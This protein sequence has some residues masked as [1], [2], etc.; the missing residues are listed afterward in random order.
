MLTNCKSFRF[1]YIITIH[2]KQD[3]IEDVLN[4]VISCCGSNSYIYTVLDG[5]KD[6]S[7][8]IIDKIIKLNG[9]VPIQKIYVDNV[10]ETLS[11]NA[12]LQ[13]A[14]QSEDGFNITLQD[15]VVLQ[16]KNFESNIQAAYQYLGYKNVGVLSFRLGVNI[17]LN[18]KANE[19]AEF[20]V[21]ESSYGVGITNAP[22]LPGGILKRMIGVRSPECISTEVVRNVGL[23]D[24]ILAPYSYCNH[25]YGIRCLKHGYRSYVMALPFE[26]DLK[27]GGTRTNPHPEYMEIHKRNRRYL[28][29]KH[30]DFLSTLPVSE[31]L[32]NNAQPFYPKNIVIDNQSNDLVLS[33]YQKKRKALLDADLIVENILFSKLNIFKQ[34]L[35]KNIKKYFVPNLRRILLVYRNYKISKEK[36]KYSAYR[37]DYSVDMSFTNTMT[38]YSDRNNVYQYMHH[39]YYHYLPIELK[40]HREYFKVNQRWF[41]EDAFYSMWWLLFREF[42]PKK[43]LEIGVYRGQVISL[44]ALISKLLNNEIN[45]YGISPLSNCGD[46]ASIYPN[47]I[48]YEADIYKSFDVFKLIHPILIKAF[49]CENKAIN[50]ISEHQWDVIYVDGGHDYSDVVNDLNTCIPALKNGGILVMDDS[51]LGTEYKPLS[52]AFAGHIDPSRA[53]REIASLQ[54]KFIGSCGHNNVFM[55]K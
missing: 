21:V 9:R 51:S 30:M 20:D 38:T 13:A 36:K 6:Q 49:S 15:D 28:Y 35:F 2:N 27:W 48:A 11:I 24:P 25:D 26:S 1:N 12:G 44:W 16:D 17:K 29:N 10:H 34:I 50:L 55:K 3:V 52:F 46:I 18:Y 45:L 5:C 31:F 37:R 43:C 39:Y 8:S 23:L 42:K 19:I 22:L 4:A 41:G 47:N 14:E 33:V 40:R 53:V 32:T 54:L 7:E